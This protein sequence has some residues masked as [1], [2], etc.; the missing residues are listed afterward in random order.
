MRKWG[1]YSPPEIIYGKKY[2]MTAQ[3]F[4]ESK[5]TCQL[6][7]IIEQHMDKEQYELTRRVWNR[8]GDNILIGPDI[9][10][11]S[12]PLSVLD[13]IIES[14]PFFVIEVLSPLTRRKDHTIKK[15]LYEKFGVKEYWLVEPNADFIEVYKLNTETGKYY[16]DGI[17]Q[18]LW[19]VDWNELTADE[20]KEFPQS[21]ELELLDK[22]TIALNEI[23]KSYHHTINS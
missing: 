7:K 18:K 22:N 12:Q 13:D 2:R 10:M 21:I 9:A 11:Y 1:E 3:G 14:I 5:V 23:F 8:F 20:K 19:E 15:E 4:I 16:L 17:Y 6:T